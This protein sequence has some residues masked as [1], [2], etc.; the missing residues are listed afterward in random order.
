MATPVP[1]RA[2]GAPARGA[3][4]GSPSHHT[5]SQVTEGAAHPSAIHL[6]FHQR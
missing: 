3:G 4:Q 5:G 2:I 1:T 6:D